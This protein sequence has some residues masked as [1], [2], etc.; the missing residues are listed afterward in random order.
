[1]SQATPLSPLAPAST[2]TPAAISSLDRIVRLLESLERR[3]STLS[4]R[5]RMADA[6]YISVRA[7]AD[8]LGISE[9][10][11]RRAIGRGELPAA[12]VGNGKRASWRIKA[13]DLDAWI[14][15]EKVTELPPAP[16]YRK[17]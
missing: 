10:T 4:D 16:T 8:R 7:A 5:L 1:M 9:T 12:D 17:G 11:I 14:L 13:T 3:L 6:A 2:E 15:R